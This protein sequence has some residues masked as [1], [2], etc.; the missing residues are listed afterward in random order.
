[1]LVAVVDAVMVVV[2]VLVVVV[3]VVVVVPL[4]LMLGLFLFLW[5]FVVGCFLCLCL[6]YAWIV[7]V[8]MLGL[9]LPQEAA[10]SV[11]LIKA[12]LCS[13]TATAPPNLHLRSE[14]RLAP[15][16]QWLTPM[17]CKVNREPGNGEL[18]SLRA[19]RGTVEGL[20]GIWP[21]CWVHNQTR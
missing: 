21:R 15:G 14:H 20:A 6:D 3:V 13:Q 12:V 10:S 1:M 7:L 5:L 11:A 17:C 4:V 18:R 8:L 16:S 19:K 2:A 9:M